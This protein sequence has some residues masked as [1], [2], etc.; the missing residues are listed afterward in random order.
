MKIQEIYNELKKIDIGSNKTSWDF[1]KERAVDYAVKNELNSAELPY[2]YFEIEKGNEI[3]DDQFD[4]LF[5]GILEFKFPKTIKQ[6]T[7][8]TI[9]ETVDGK[10]IDRPY[11]SG[12][13]EV[14]NI[15]P[16]ELNELVYK[17]KDIIKSYE[18]TN[19]KN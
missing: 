18:R 10:E 15:V 12:T 7:Y 3:T 4:T 5:T 19:A 8:T 17:I 2:I 11:L 6:D 13:I 16:V 14:E 1:V 9:K